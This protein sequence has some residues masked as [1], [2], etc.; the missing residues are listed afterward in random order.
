MNDDDV[1]TAVR[2]CAAGVRMSIPAERIIS[3]GQGLRFRRRIRVAA[4][5][6][7]AVA[8]GAVLAVTSLAAL[9]PSRPSAV[10]FTAWTV[11][12]K[13]GGAVA[14]S[15]HELRDPAGLERRIRADGVPASVTY[16]GHTNPHC[17]PFPADIHRYEHVFP[18]PQ[19][20]PGKSIPAKGLFG[21]VTP[22]GKVRQSHLLLEIWTPALPRGAGVQIAATV[23]RGQMILAEPKLVYAQPK[24]T[25]S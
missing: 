21:V 16:Y 25:G 5:G 10:R 23:R 11:V 19:P 22:G 18:L 13:P 24:C 2:Q 7:L 9:A 20:I 1:I 8:T 4:V 15:I 14:I 12:S 6:A 17:H 3:R